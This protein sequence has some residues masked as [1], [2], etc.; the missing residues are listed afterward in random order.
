MPLLPKDAAAV[1][2]EEEDGIE[3]LKASAA[4]TAPPISLSLPPPSLPHHH[5]HTH[6][7]TYPPTQEFAAANPGRTRVNAVLGGREA[8]PDGTPSSLLLFRGAGQARA[9]TRISLPS[10]SSVLL[11]SLAPLAW[12]CAAERGGRGSRGVD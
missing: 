6:T 11:S 4:E 12:L 3:E 8:R 1:R 9:D 5:T 2:G 7:H 10:S